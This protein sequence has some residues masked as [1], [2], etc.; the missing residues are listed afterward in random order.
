MIKTGIGTGGPKAGNLA[1]NIPVGHFCEVQAPLEAVAGRN[2][3]INNVPGKSRVTGAEDF[4]LVIVAFI[5]HGIGIEGDK[6]SAGFEVIH[7]AP[8]VVIL[9]KKAMKAVLHHEA[10]IAHLY[11]PASDFAPQLGRFFEER[12][13]DTT[14][15]QLMG[16]GQAG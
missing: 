6:V 9:G 8:Q 14:L 15:A 16:A 5:N 13:F 12:Y 2:A 10:M 1:E 4:W 7:Q 3:Q 11:R